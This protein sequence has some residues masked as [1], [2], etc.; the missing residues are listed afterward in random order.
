M[1]KMV[2]KMGRKECKKDKPEGYKMEYRKVGCNLN[3]LVGHMMDSNLLE[4]ASS[5]NRMVGYK[6]DKPAGCKLECKLVPGM[7]DKKAGSCMLG[8]L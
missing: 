4:I 7:M 1:D 3:K 8:S 2:C 6:M 5:C